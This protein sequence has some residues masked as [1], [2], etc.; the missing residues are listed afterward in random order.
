MN[1]NYQTKRKSAN[2]KDIVDFFTMLEDK[3]ENNTEKLQ[4]LIE[5][6]NKYTNSK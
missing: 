1:T 6:F 4:S 3:F 2:D 5:I